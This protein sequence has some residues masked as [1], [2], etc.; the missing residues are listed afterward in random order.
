MQT[1][2]KPINIQN[3]T[4]NA[5]LT[6]I[7]QSRFD[8]LP[9]TDD[10]IYNRTPTVT[11][12]CVLKC[13]MSCIPAASAETN[14]YSRWALYVERS[15]IFRHMHSYSFHKLAKFVPLANPFNGVHL[16]RFN[17]IKPKTY[18]MYHQLYLS[19]V[20][21]YPQCICVFCVDLRTNTDYFSIQH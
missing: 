16:K 4:N 13:L 15:I 10:S 14:R 5:T 12:A 7:K 21:F 6:L 2:S 17:L 11:M 18:F 9:L 19:E 20:V 8:P 3:T 1:K